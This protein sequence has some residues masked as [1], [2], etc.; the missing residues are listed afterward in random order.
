MV[1]VLTVKRVVRSIMTV[2]NGVLDCSCQN[3]AITAKII[4]MASREKATKQI[5]TN[6]FK[7]ENHKLV[8]GLN[9]IMSMTETVTHG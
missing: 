2:V 9:N 5:K 1:V 7:T 6:G 4:S 3:F 8:Y